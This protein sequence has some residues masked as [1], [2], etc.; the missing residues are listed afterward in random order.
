M[1]RSRARPYDPAMR[2]RAYV[3]TDVEAVR[4]AH[5][6]AHERIMSALEQQGREL[7]GAGWRLF[8]HI[9]WSLYIDSQTIDEITPL[10]VVLDRAWPPSR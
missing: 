8:S 2:L 7:N 10:S 3:T 4:A 6:A 5:L 1:Q 9:A